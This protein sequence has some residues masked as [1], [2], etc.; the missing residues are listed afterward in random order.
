ME[1]DSPVVVRSGSMR[2]LTLLF[3]MLMIGFLFHGAP[4]ALEDWPGFLGPRRDGSSREA[5]LIAGWAESGLRERWRRPVGNGYSG[6]AVSGGLVFTMDSDGPS[7]FVFAS[8]AESGTELWRLRLGDAPR[9]WY[10]GLG[11]RGTPSVDG[12][13]LFVTTAGGDLLSL[14]TDRGEVLWRRPLTKELGWRPPAEG[15]ASS[16]LVAGSSVFVMIGGGKGRAAAALDRETGR[17][18]WVSGDGRV[19]YSSP[20]QIGLA[21]R[22]QLLFLMAADLLALDPADG[23]QLWSHPWETYDGVNVAV[24][25]AIGSDRVFI[26]AGYDQGAALL[27]VEKK[28]AAFQVSE[29]WRNREMK[30]HFNNSV[31]HK[32]VFYGFDN[33]ILKA[34]SAADGS[35]LWR[36]RGFGKGSVLLAGDHLVVLGERGELALVEASPESCR[37]VKRSQVLQGRCWTPPSIAAGRLYLRNQTHMVCLQVDG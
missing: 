34:V 27:R 11:P 3:S 9:D 14:S 8:S 30:N 32:G 18:I 25:L 23:R 28:G 35:T 4:S 13:R 19:S 15:T 10:G 29:I 7:E 33:S 26:S 1:P 2:L 24:P 17:T 22:P 5:N 20:L 37:I 6:L 21:G 36:E 12:D 16:P 31:F